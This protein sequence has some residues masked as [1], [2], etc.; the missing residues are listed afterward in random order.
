METSRRARSTNLKAS[1]DIL[2]IGGG[3]T[4]L[5]V[6]VDAAT[7]GFSVLLVEQSDFAKATSSRSTKLIHGGLRY[8]EQGD[9]HLVH[10]ALHERGLLCQNASEIV[11]PLPFVIP[12]FRWWH[13]PFYGIGLKAY[14]WLAGRR[15]LAPS[16]F[17]GAQEAR[18]RLPNV[19]HSGLRGGILYFDGQFDDARLALALAHTAIAHGATVLNY[20]PAISVHK[21]GATINVDGVLH[22]VR[23]QLVINAA[24][25]FSDEIRALD[26]PSARP[27]IRHSRGVHLVLGSSFMPSQSA[28][29]IPRTDDGRLLFLTPWLGKL[30]L[31]TTDVTVDHPELEP[32]PSAEEV[33]FLLHHAARYLTRAPKRSDVLSCFAGLRPLV[34]KGEEKS[35]ALSREHRILL[36]PNGLLSIMGGK[37]TTYRKMAQDTLDF[38]GAHSLIEQRPCQ[39]ET[40]R[41]LTSSSPADLAAATRQAVDKE[42]ALTVEDVLARRTRTL[43]LDARKAIDAAPQVASLMGL[44]PEAAFQ[45]QSLAHNYLL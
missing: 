41:L 45:F 28:M 43:F 32:R 25:I 40:L 19:K 9:I 3:A 30:L 4:G 7:R 22:E 35:S 18:A 16:K 8:L 14:D 36:S 15:N 10:E 34:A 39:T 44:P 38:A 2:I 42:M 17:I 31:G 12:L 23:A 21:Q 29:L 6:A 27:L 37:W 20:T 1:Y 26:D 11:H 33:D 24:G 13:R 5:G